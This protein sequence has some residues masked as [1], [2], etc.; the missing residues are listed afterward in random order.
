MIPEWPA[1]SAQCTAA[2]SDWPVSQ[3]S[4]EAATDC[5]V[6]PLSVEQH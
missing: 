5:S 1:L 6:I 4:M 2:L 3:C